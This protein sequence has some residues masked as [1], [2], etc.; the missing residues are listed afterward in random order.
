[1]KY[2]YDNNTV[3]RAFQNCNYDNIVKA[4]NDYK[5]QLERNV[6]S[7][8]KVLKALKDT[9]DAMESLNELSNE[10]RNRFAN[11]MILALSGLKILNK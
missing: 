8:E 2:T 1:M 10:E 4:I 6:K 9:L 3:I 11:Y 7:D 5:N